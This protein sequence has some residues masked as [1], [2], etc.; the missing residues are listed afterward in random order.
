MNEPLPPE[1]QTEEVTDI[2]TRSDELAENYDGF[3]IGNVEEYSGAAEHLRMIKS[4][5][6][7]VE[8]QRKE[9]TQPLVASQRAANAF[10]KPFADRLSNA[11]RAIK[12]AMAS[13]KS[14]QDR[15]AREEQRKRDQEAERK[16]KEQQR[17]AQAARDKG[18]HARAQNLEAQAAQSVAPVVRS[19]APKAEGISYRKVWNFRITDE[20][21]IPRK[22][23]V[24]DEK[25]LRQVVK[26]LGSDAEIPGV[27]VYSEDQVA[28]RSS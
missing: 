18:R 9:I 19:E 10:F 2:T 11:E 17:Q 27:E 14:E 24:V 4:M 21:K 6:K 28:A 16:R 7:E 25:K 8:D 26:A 15:I 3:S 1:L 20:A 22:Y 23:L 5:Q 12:Q 13:W